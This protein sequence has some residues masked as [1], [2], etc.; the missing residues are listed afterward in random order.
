M[1]LIELTDVVKT[2]NEKTSPV[3]ALSGVSLRIERGE[4]IAL[5]GSSGSGKTTLLNILAAIDKPSSGMV[6]IDGASI[7]SMTDAELTLFRR[8]KIGIVF[9]FFNLM[10]TLTVLE[11]VSLPAL[12]LKSD[13]KESDDR[14]KKLI[15]RVGLSHR[16][17]HKPFQ[18]SGG[19][20]QRTAIARALMNNPDV[21]IADEPTGNLD[22]K[23][24]EQILDL[25]CTLARD[26]QKTF[27]IATHA[28]DV[29]EKAGRIVQMKDGKTVSRSVA[30]VAE[31]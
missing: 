25:I 3:Y 14:A 27:V 16:L 19:E 4:F 10:P 8:K 22:S 30:V 28:S 7:G 21:I 13:K 31:S 24:A 15:E 23:N 2:Y 17:E 29:S 20:M 6:T 5:I 26:E 9:Q 12:L 18:L 11:N 1:S